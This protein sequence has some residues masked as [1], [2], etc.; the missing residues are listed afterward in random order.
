MSCFCQFF[1]NPS[2]R[3]FNICGNN[4][5]AQKIT[6]V[7]AWGQYERWIYVY[8][9]E[10]QDYMAV[11]FFRFFSIWHRNPLKE[12]IVFLQFMLTTYIVWRHLFCDPCTSLGVIVRHYYNGHRY[13]LSP[14]VLV[15]Y[16][17]SLV[18]IF[19]AE[20]KNTHR[21]CRKFWVNNF[22]SI[23]LELVTFKIEIMFEIKFNLN[24]QVEPSIS[25]FEKPWSIIPAHPI[26][27]IG[28]MYSA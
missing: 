17:Q 22:S 16:V 20:I 4:V 14:A 12:L 18:C 28:Y 5:I 1:E 21:K 15:G 19:G 8:P 26:P 23:F 27:C 10:F 6:R 25:L 2:F 9:L 13:L 3:W 7:Y 11:F 24:S